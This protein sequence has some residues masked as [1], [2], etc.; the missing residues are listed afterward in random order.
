MP[1]RPDAD[2]SDALC[3]T[4]DASESGIAPAGAFPHR[5]AVRVSADGD[6]VLR[7][8]HSPLRLA[9]IT[10]AL[11]T[12]G[13]I[14]LLWAIAGTVS[15]IAWNPQR[16]MASALVV[17]LAVTGAAVSLWWM[18]GNTTWRVTATAVI[19]HRSLFGFR[20]GQRYSHPRFSMHQRGGRSSPRTWLLLVRSQDS[21]FTPLPAFVDLDRDRSR[22]ELVARSLT[23]GQHASEQGGTQA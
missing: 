4:V 6:Q 2:S 22:L 10:L 19:A 13:W 18:F 12:G 17:G 16:A 1:S 3:A 9:G 15:P 5:W 21:L 8:E 11:V 7:L 14:L 23:P 20:W